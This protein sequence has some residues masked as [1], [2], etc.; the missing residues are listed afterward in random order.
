MATDILTQLAN[1]ETI[2]SLSFS[3]KMTGGLLVTCLGMG[4]TF[5]ALILL[6]LVMD[7]LAK[8]TAKKERKPSLTSVAPVTKFTEAPPG[9]K[10]DEELIAVISATVAM[11][12]Q[13]PSGEIRIRNIR[14]VEEPSPSWNRAGILEQMNTR[15]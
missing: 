10:N 15:L 13:K 11:M 5:L 9:K 14:K 8:L 1:P 3:Q 2:K 4:I 7:L 6:Q 12:M